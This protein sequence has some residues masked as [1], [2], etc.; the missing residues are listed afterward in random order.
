MSKSSSLQKLDMSDFLRKYN[1]Q[2]HLW[3]TR[4]KCG[5]SKVH[6]YPH[7]VKSDDPTFKPLINQKS[8]VLAKD[9]V[10][11]EKRALKL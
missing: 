11:I 1:N 7:E 4:I 2:V 6:K 8:K 5:T 3:E 9:M 10:K